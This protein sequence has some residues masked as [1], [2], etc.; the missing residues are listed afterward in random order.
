[1]NWQ[2]YSDAIISK[3][4]TFSRL[5]VLQVAINYCSIVWHHSLIKAQAEWLGVV[6]CEHFAYLSISNWYA[7]CGRTCLCSVHLSLQLSTTPEQRVFQFCRWAISCS[8]PITSCTWRFQ[9]C[10]QTVCSICIPISTVV[11]LTSQ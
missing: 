7:L 4:S 2:T 8:F 9:C 1:M 10:L 3:A 11:Q 6:W 5:H